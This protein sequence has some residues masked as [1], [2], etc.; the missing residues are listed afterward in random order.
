MRLRARYVAAG[1]A[2]LAYLVASQWLMTRTPPPPWSAAALL[3]PMLALLALGLW[4]AGRRAWSLCGAA[5]VV[6]LVVHAAFGDGF[7]AERLYLIEHVAFH[8]ALAF[9]FGLTLRR[10]A[11]PLISRL[12]DRV[13]RGLTPAMEHYTRKVT[14]AWTV[15]F[16]AMAALSLGLYLGATF[17]AWA[18]F[19]NVGTPVAL[20][21]MFG[22]EYL[23]RYRLHPEFERATMQDAI[24]A[25]AQTRHAPH[26]GA[27][28]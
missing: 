24:R 23:L 20:A 13:H 21:L 15:Y 25:W 2:A 26:R 28:P 10:G 6:A 4:R 22:G 5:A 7:D 11:R 19:A 27:E 17:A 9:G 16:V 14:L 18:T 8:I 3:G 12:A 1:A